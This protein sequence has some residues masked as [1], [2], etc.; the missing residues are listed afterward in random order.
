MPPRRGSSFILALSYVTM[1]FRIAM[2]QP[3]GRQSV[4]RPSTKHPNLIHDAQLEIDIDK[5]PEKTFLKS[6]ETYR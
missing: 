5:L 1:P 6:P 4:G 2:P 3:T